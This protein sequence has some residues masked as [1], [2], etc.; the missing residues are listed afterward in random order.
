M[1]EAEET[2]AEAE[3]LTRALEELED[4]YAEVEAARVLRD[5][6]RSE[7]EAKESELRELE[8][9][10]GRYYQEAIDLHRKHL[11]EK[12]IRELESMARE[13]P[14]ATDDELVR[15]LDE[16]RVRLDDTE[17]LGRERLEKLLSAGE[18][19]DGLVQM[20]EAG[21]RDFGSFRSRFR[22]GLGLDVLLTEYMEGMESWSGVIDRMNEVHFKPPIVE[23]VL[24]GILSELAASF[25]LSP[26]D[27]E[28]S[29]DS[30]SESLLSTVVRDPGSRLVSRRVT[31][32]RSE[33]ESGWDRG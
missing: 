6:A 9:N 5:K 26:E 12:P 17:R 7:D 29:I 28:Y 32:R 30:D 14:G 1:D 10:R 11:G 8:T 16:V 21:Q 19:V 2:A 4:V 18:R 27:H 23:S 3:G 20:E 13:T 31:R 15:R 25:S 24:G 22:E 33:R